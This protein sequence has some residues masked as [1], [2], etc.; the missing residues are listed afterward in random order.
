MSSNTN[1]GPINQAHGI[2]NKYKNLQVTFNKNFLFLLFQLQSQIGTEDEYKQLVTNEMLTHR[3]TFWQKLI[4]S[5]PDSEEPRLNWMQQSVL[6]DHLL[7]KEVDQLA[8]DDTNIIIQILENAFQTSG[9]DVTSDQDRHQIRCYI[10][11][12][13]AEDKTNFWNAVVGL[14]RIGALLNIKSNIPGLDKIVSAFDHTAEAGTSQLNNPKT[15]TKILKTKKTMETAVQEMMSHDINDATFTSMFSNLSLVLKS[16]KTGTGEKNTLNDVMDNMVTGMFGN[17][18][19]PDF[20]HGL[21]DIL[22]S[23]NLNTE[24]L[25]KFFAENS[26]NMENI[27]PGFENMMINEESKSTARSDPVSD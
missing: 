10:N 12:L 24:T 8:E 26:K 21:T 16:F 6:A 1:L 11:V 4:D 22:H 25:E 3:L 5:E 19:S 20:K 14:F 23:D 18:V 2:V 7:V 13:D 9:E 15:I 17:D 27:M